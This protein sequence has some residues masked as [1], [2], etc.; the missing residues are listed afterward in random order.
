MAPQLTATELDFLRTLV[1][2]GLC[3]VE[4][5]ARLA[6]R[7]GRSGKAN[8]DLTTV[9]RALRG[10]THP[11]SRKETRGR[12]TKLTAVRLRRLNTVRKALI[13]KAGGEREIHWEE[14]MKK[15]RVN[16]VHPST[17]SRAFKKIG[18][19]WRAPREK[20]SRTADDM[21]ERVTICSRWRFL[22]DNYFTEK[23]DLIMD[24]KKFDVPTYARAKKF[25]KMR[26]VRGHL[27]TK[28]EG[29]AAGFTKP[30]VR[31]NRV[32]P[33]AKVNVCAGVIGCQVKLWHYLPDRW[34]GDAAAA[35]YSGPVI[36]TLRAHRGNKASYRIL[37]D[38]DPTGYYSGKGIFAKK[39]AGILPIAFPKYSPDLNPLDFYIWAEVERR[40]HEQEEGGKYKKETVNE[41]KKRLRR[42][43][44]SLPADVIR[45]AVGSLKQRAAAV[46][47]A[48]GDN[49]A[50]D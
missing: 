45:K 27:R 10:L 32:N 18:I 22:P 42:T 48:G 1:G 44:L 12:K 28:G 31:K 43:A 33:G 7:R 8:A 2:K 34:S 19:A 23:V 29:L 40:M 5:H 11:A 20:P 41:Y 38:N 49:I 16:D 17:V 14:I 9:R 3:P 39:E 37:E 24:N 50:L 46:V 25:H 36:K 4:A 15:A 6:A 30:N 13:K 21:K 47:A 26:R 35:L